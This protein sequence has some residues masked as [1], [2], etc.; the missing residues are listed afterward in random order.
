MDDLDDLEP[1]EGDQ[2]PEAADAGPTLADLKKLRSENKGLR[3]RLKE[4]Q[5]QILTT[6]FDEEVLGLIPEEVTDFDR[7]VQLAEQ[8]QAR[9]K[10]SS[11]T[12]TE[13]ATDAPAPEADSAE[14]QKLAA[15]GT[16]P[17]TGAAAPEAL[18]TVAEI[19]E[20][21]KTDP[22]TANRLIREGKFVQQ[23]TW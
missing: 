4:A 18:M 7:R 10:P 9:F 13:P 2:T 21:G 17:Q 19:K 16:G 15:V 5:N 14:E 20:L 8:Y 23:N 3:E 12:Q 11:E 22:D 6:R 1:Q